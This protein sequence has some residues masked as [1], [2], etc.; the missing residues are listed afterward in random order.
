MDVDSLVPMHRLPN[1][2]SC[3]LTW[4]YFL[5]QQTLDFLLL[6]NIDHRCM[7]L[8]VDQM[9]DRSSTRQQ[10]QQEQ[11]EVECS[12][13]TEAAAAVVVVVVAAAEEE[14]IHLERQEQEGRANN[15]R[16]RVASAM[17]KHQCD[18][19]TSMDVRRL[20][21]CTRS[22]IHHTIHRFGS[23]AADV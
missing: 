10:R 2:P 22:M 6:K 15:V 12:I 19:C 14:N 1:R 17:T 11:R 4:S 21:L 23:A 18:C 16:K 20:C 13:L 3:C 9:D 7:L 5:V 8:L